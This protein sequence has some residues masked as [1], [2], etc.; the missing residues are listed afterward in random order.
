MV[1]WY[2]VERYEDERHEDG[3]VAVLD[4]GVLEWCVG[5]VGVVG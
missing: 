2:S 4:V 1:A 5:L 3:E